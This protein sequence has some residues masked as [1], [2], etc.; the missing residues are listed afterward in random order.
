M[1]ETIVFPGLVYNSV[2]LKRRSKNGWYN[3]D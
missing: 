1:A 2:I 3:E